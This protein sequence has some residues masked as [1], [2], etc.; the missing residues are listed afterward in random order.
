MSDQPVI[1]SSTNKP[2][3]VQAIEVMLLVSGILNILAGLSATCGALV[4][5]IGVLCLP[6][7]ALPLALGIFEVIYASNLLSGKL[8][9][10]NNIKTVAIFEIASILYGNVFTFIVGILN[11]VFLDDKPVR[12]YFG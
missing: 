12:E 11:L 6:V 3:K 10:A 9:L 2:G 1:I 7:V 8:V 5:I 4:S